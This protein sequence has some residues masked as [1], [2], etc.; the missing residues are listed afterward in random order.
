MAG[1]VCFDKDITID[2]DREC[3]ETIEGKTISRMAQ[4]ARE[5]NSYIVSGCILERR[6][7]DFYNT[8][9]LLDPQGKV[10]TIFSKIHLANYWG[11]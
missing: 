5:V 1:I 7:E 3:S 6:G 10:V 9:V 2:K 11:Y 8:I 4:K